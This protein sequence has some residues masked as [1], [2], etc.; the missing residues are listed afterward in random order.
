MSAPQ[1]GGCSSEG[2]PTTVGFDPQPSRDAVAPVRKCKVLFN[3][4]DGVQACGRVNGH[5]GAHTRDPLPSDQHAF[6]AASEQHYEG[7][8]RLTWYG[9]ECD[10]DIGEI[11]TT[12]ISEELIELEGKRVR[13]TV[14][15][16]P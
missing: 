9:D 5:P 15:V 3:T 12:C 1:D 14:E 10:I 6:S 2:A 16:L 4:F 13:V 11:G 8:V 7:V